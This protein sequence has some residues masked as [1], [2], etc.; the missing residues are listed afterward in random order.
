MTRGAQAGTA[1]PTRISS[2]NGRVQAGQSVSGLGDR[3]ER[4][5][6]ILHKFG[7]IYSRS[8]AKDIANKF[9]DAAFT[10]NSLYCIVVKESLCITNHSYK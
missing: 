4:N 10:A 9:R 8:R 6:P 1:G 3:L 7:A 2:I 5:C